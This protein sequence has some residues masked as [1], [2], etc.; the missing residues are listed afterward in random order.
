VEKYILYGGPKVPR[1]NKK[2]HG[3]LKNSASNE[4]NSTAIEKLSVNL[5]ER[6]E[7]FQSF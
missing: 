1:K 6:G 4:K 2:L 5:F 3:K 7:N